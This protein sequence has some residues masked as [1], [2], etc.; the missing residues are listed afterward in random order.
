MIPRP[1]K[2]LSVHLSVLRRAW[3]RML[4]DYPGQLILA[5]TGIALGIAVVVSIDLAKESALAAFI[6]ATETLSGRASYRIVGDSGTLDERLFPKLRLGALPFRFVPKIE[7]YVRIDS[8]NGDKLR[9]LGVDPFSEVGFGSFESLGARSLSKS[10]RRNL[11]KLLTRPAYA[12]ISRSTA[13]RLHLQAGE[14]LAI[15]SAGEK[16]K[17][18]IAALPDFS[19][20]L[21]EQA[22]EDLI[23]TDIASAQEILELSGRISYIE[24]LA[25][26]DHIDPAGLKSLKQQLPLTVELVSYRRIQ[27]NARELTASFYTNLTALSLLSVLVGMFLIYNTV[28]FLT[29]RRR[30]LT[31]MLRAL[32]ASRTQIIYLVL[33]ESALLGFAGTLAGLVLGTLLAHGM[34]DLI[35]NTIDNVYF[36]L[37]KAPLKLSWLAFAKGLGLGT[38]VS[39]LSA[40]PPAREAVAGEAFRALARSGLESQSRR[41]AITSAV[42]GMLAAGAGIPAI[43]L[44][45][46]SITYGFAGLMLLVLGCALL[47]PCFLILLGA[48]LYPPMLKLFGMLGALPLRSLKA[49]LSRS[50]LAVAALLVAIS[51]TVGVEIMVA[52]F[53]ISVGAWLEQRLSADLYISA[54]G[55]TAQNSPLNEQFRAKIARLEGIRAI[56]T[57]RRRTLQQADGPQQLSVYALIPEV[58]RGFRFLSGSAERIWRD[59]AVNDAVIVSESYAYHHELK[60]GSVVTLRT[61]RG[62]K[63]FSVRGIYRDYNPGPGVIGMSHA[64][65]RRHWHDPEYSGISIYAQ[66]GTDLKQLKRSL[67]ALSDKGQAL[68]IS[69]RSTILKTSL[70]VFDQAF[71]VTGILQWL[72]ATIA[73][74]GVFSVLSAIQ[75]DRVRE[76]GI[77]RAIGITSRQLAVLVVAESGLMGAV[78]GLLALPVG[79]LIATV[80]IYVINQRSFGW[81]ISFHIPPETLV[82]GLLSGMI[83]AVLAGLLPAYRMSRLR[84]EEALRNE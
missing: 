1:R 58:T 17:I 51:A 13:E 10:E 83:A 33:S 46:K 71:A 3:H 5:L 12:V 21:E 40:I 30:S 27:Q 25:A 84:P 39:V 55:A 42:F 76:Y 29:I 35:A 69:E 2:S 54:P 43:L 37:P 75:L 28:H 31:G 57:V 45:G 67:H 23:L 68:E 34:L 16:K 49:N 62:P 53:R 19:E 41:Q 7:G 4:L 63:E 6:E 22:M 38:A 74:L 82:H 70:S 79:I 47:A 72:A 78:A 8:P 26:K 20:P 44:S 36:T 59:L 61:D 9:I 64:T 24:V 66:P 73:F 32:G 52:S 60:I 18:R 15:L 80:L 48:L 81:S 50:G 65:Y 14:D 56:G 77:L 11:V